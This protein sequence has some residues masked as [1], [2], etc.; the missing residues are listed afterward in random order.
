MPSGTGPALLMFV[1][2]QYKLLLAGNTCS[3]NH[4]RIVSGN[5]PSVTVAYIQIDEI[6][7]QSLIFKL[8]FMFTEQTLLAQGVVRGVYL[9]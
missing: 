3:L 9:Y 5:Q 7:Y 4:T 6:D 1:V 2:I 8:R